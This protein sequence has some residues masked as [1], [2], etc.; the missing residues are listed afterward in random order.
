[1]L[2]GVKIETISFVSVYVH[3]N[4]YY[5]NFFFIVLTMFLAQNIL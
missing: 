2:L 1:M 5:S 4:L 3:K